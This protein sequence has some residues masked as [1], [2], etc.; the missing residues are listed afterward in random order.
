MLSS[1]ARLPFG[2][3]ARRALEHYRLCRGPYRGSAKQIEQQL[4]A[5]V[6][7]VG[8]DRLPIR[9]RFPLLAAWLAALQQT[10]PPAARP[11]RRILFLSVMAHWVEFCFPVAV[12]LAGRGCLVDY[13][14]L[15]YHHME[16]PCDVPPPPSRL[17]RLLPHVRVH[18]RLHLVNLLNVAPSLVSE[19]LH[20]LARRAGEFDVRYLL[21]RERIDF[22]DDEPARQLAAFRAERNLEC[23]ARLT[24]LLRR[25]H[26]DFALIPN[27]A[28]FEFR[29]ACELAQ[30]SGLPYTTFD[31]VDRKEAIVASRNQVCVHLPTNDLWRADAPH[32]LSPEREARVLAW[33]RRRESPNWHEGEYNWH[34]QLAA[35][36]SAARLRKHL[37]LSEDKRVALLCTNVAHDTAV[38]GQTL[39]FSSMAEWIQETIAWFARRPDWQLVIRCHPVEAT[40]PSGEPV[41]QLIAERFPHL[42][43]NVQVIEPAAPV[44]TYSLMR[45]CDLGLVYT[46]TTGLEMAARGIPVIVAG[47]VHYSGRGFT[48][49]PSNATEYFAAL[50]RLAADGQPTTRREIELG[51]CYADIYFNQLPKPFPWWRAGDIAADVASWPVERILR[52]ECPEPFLQ[53]LDYLGGVV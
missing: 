22:A 14:W 37:R 8:P 25:R 53:T 4:L 43:G 10:P 5:L 7:K 24:T 34:G 15:P 31:F 44:N 20:A 13:V 6:L 17:R 26:Y 23:L 19:E 40:M 39:A 18:P 52:G 12:A 48:N 32:V 11:L 45:L 30:Q 41:P 50:E 35:T 1:L 46:T 16:L 49:D 2:N 51:L 42:P 27:G 33:L 28:V 47:K 21:R 9:T 3:S 36:E 29:M 38:L